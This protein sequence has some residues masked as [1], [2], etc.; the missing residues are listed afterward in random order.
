VTGGLAGSCLQRSMM[1]YPALQSFKWSR[2]TSLE[3]VVSWPG[4]TDCTGW[5]E[6]VCPLVKPEIETINSAVWSAQL[7]GAAAVVDVSVDAIGAGTGGFR[8]IVNGERFSPDFVLA[9]EEPVAI[10]FERATGQYQ[11]QLITGPI[12]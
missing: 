6:P 2:G 11:D 10:R 4:R 5:W 8:M 12:S 7:L 1:D 9:V 3:V